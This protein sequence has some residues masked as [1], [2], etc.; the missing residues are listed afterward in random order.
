MLNMKHWA[1]VVVCAAL[2]G[3]GG[4]DDGGTGTAGSSSGGGGST[5]IEGSTTAPDPTTGATTV[6][7]TT[8]TGSASGTTTGTTTADTTTS[9]TTGTTTGT[10]T[11][12]T[13]TSDTSTSTGPG[14]ACGDLVVDPGEECDDGN[15]EDADA[16]TNACKNAA[17]GDGIVGPGEACDDGNQEDADACSNM[18]ASASCGDGKTQAPEECD[19]G[20]KVDTDA[21]LGTCLAAKCGDLVVQDIVEQCDDGNLEDLDDCSNLCVL[22]TCSDK[23]KNAAE[24]DVDCGGAVCPKCGLGGVCGADSDCG[25]GVCLQQKCVSNKSCKAL[26]DGD[27]ALKDGKYMIDPD[28][29]G[30]N[31]AFEAYCDM[32]HDGGGWT[33]IMKVVNT[34]F[35]YDDP[36]WENNLT[37]NPTDFDFVTDG[38]K[39]KYQTFLSVG[40]G[41]LRSSATDGAS[42]HIQKLAGPVA[43]ATA[44]FTGP[45][46]E[47]SKTVLNTYF[48]NLSI[49]YDKHAA[50]CN[51]STKYVNYGI[52]LKKLNGVNALP[53]GGFC[54]W[55]GGARFGQ[56]VN[57]NHNAT[58]DHAG[59]GWG[60]YTTINAN[61]LTLMKQLLWVR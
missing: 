60:T 36:L 42:S 46:V 40:F 10:T 13:S 12:D 53:D 2:A 1:S 52:N 22:A 33:L 20:N 21:C 27:N 48:D 8:S 15:Q 47:I 11:G 26:F 19:D 57:G 29:G 56:R 18:C 31:P 49:P 39:A 14:P 34:N 7:P 3:C 24:T 43:S 16:C 54:D 5:T 58:G 55:N 4:G 23:L 45:G 51:P 38:K 35:L 32:T 61:Y 25:V 41:E 30:P 59:Q 37:L 44:L 28:E 17:C 9:N 6:E 50:L